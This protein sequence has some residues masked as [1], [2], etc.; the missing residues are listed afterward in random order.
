MEKCVDQWEMQMERLTAAVEAED[1]G[2]RGD[3]KGR[4]ERNAPALGL[5]CWALGF[6]PQSKSSPGFL[7][8]RR[9]R[10]EGGSGQKMLPSTVSLW[11]QAPPPGRREG[12]RETVEPVC[13]LSHHLSP[14]TLMHHRALH[15]GIGRDSWGAFAGPSHP[16]GWEFHPPPR[17]SYE[18]GDSR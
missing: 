11:R 8:A 9:K 14:S 15:A 6:K 3:L 7:M 12:W 4:R 5:R 1:H 18:H 10:A 2:N 13:H 16:S 17:D